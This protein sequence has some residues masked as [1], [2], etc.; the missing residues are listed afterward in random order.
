LTRFIL[1][2]QSRRVRKQHKKLF[3]RGKSRC[4]REAVRTSFSLY[5]AHRIL[6]ERL[7]RTYNLHQSVCIQ[8]LLDLEARRGLL[9][10]EVSRLLSQRPD[11]SHTEGKEQP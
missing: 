1:P 8:L 7:E 9:R 3:A 5:P 6:L 10:E 4:G 2:A 11:D